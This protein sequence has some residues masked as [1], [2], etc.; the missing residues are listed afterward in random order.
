[1]QQE[2]EMIFVGDDWSE[3]QHDVTILG[4]QGQQLEH[5]A[6]SDTV[7]G[8]R[9]LQAVLAEHADTIEEVMIGIETSSGLL[10]QLLIAAGYQVYVINPL[11]AS[12]YRQRHSVSGAK[13]DASDSKMLADM[14]RIDRHNHRRYLGDTELAAAIKVLARSHKELIWSRQRHVNQLRSTLRL[15]YPAILG[16]VGDLGGAEALAL[17]DRALTP[18]EGRSL[19]QSKIRS[20][21]ESAGRKRGIEAR[22]QAIQEGLRSPQLE[23]PPLVSRA[24]GATVRALVDVVR[25]TNRQ[26]A[27]LEAELAQSFE[28][29]PD[30]EI[31]R[32]LPGLGA[33][34]GARVLAEFGD[35]PTR[36][37]DAR[38][39]KNYA[40]TSPITKASG[41]KRVVLARY[42]RDLW[43]AD[44][45]HWWAFASLMASAGA[46]RY[47]DTL[48]GRGQAHNAALRMLAN[49]WVG[50]LHVCLHSRQRY[51]EEVAWPGVE[52]AA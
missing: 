14:V 5:L 17:L 48:R 10:T 21:V 19:S 27:G 23:A 12:G 24:Y 45:L 51:V 30:A 52:A 2:E 44:T 8:A 40:G 43:L 49:R 1:V 38:A 41:K 46:R 47:Y 18:A 13:S 35:E 42:V 7:D 6:V 15:Y 26:I 31:I 3:A 36:F 29:H 32:S 25:A 16:V 39:R 37:A 20:L 9:R 4:D 33:V 28:R 22:V 11:A 34:L 50:I